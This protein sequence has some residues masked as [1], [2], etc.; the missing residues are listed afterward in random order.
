[1][2]KWARRLQAICALKQLSQ[3]KEQL[4][5]TIGND[6]FHCISNALTYV[7]CSKQS[8]KC[9][10]MPTSVDQSIRKYL[11]VR[12]FSPGGVG[13]NTDDLDRPARRRGIG[14]E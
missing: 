3:P 4:N 6:F 9:L 14:H 10:L 12:S 11:R 1:M 5:T 8:R 2:V 13:G 7:T